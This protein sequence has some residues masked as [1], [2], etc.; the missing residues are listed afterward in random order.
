MLPSFTKGSSA[1][2]LRSELIQDHKIAITAIL[3]TEIIS[4][5]S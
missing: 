2:I 4:P 5:K 1:S 3:L